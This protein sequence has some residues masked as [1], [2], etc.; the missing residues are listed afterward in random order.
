MHKYLRRL[1]LNLRKRVSSHV[2][3]IRPS[4]PAKSHARWRVAWLDQGQ[5][6]AVRSLTGVKKPARGLEYRPRL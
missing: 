3:A 6:R 5:W 2:L 1:A 4:A